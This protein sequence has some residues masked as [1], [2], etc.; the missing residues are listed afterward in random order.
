MHSLLA[1]V[2]FSGVGYEKDRFFKLRK[3][4]TSAE[5]NGFGFILL[6]KTQDLKMKKEEEEEHLFEVCVLD[7]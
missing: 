2:Q 7:W 6:E 5:I 3:N 4:N 1:S